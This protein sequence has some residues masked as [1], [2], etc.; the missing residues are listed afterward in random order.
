MRIRVVLRVGVVLRNETRREDDC[1]TGHGRQ[2]TRQ[3]ERERERALHPWRRRCHDID[4][5]V[6][7]DFVVVRGLAQRHRQAADGYGGV[8]GRGH[9][10]SLRTTGTTSRWRGRTTSG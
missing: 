5:T 1:W 4:P 10:I 7:A 2:P 8:A 9:E 3:C 6:A